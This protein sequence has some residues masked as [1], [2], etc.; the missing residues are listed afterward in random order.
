MSEENLNT[1]TA[2][3]GEDA[4]SVESN[5]PP[6]DIEERARLQGWV[7]KDEFKGDPEKWRPADEFVERGEQIV[8]ILKERT[9]TLESKLLEATTRLERQEAE[10]RER[11]AKIERMSELALQRQRDQIIGAYENAKLKAVEIGDTERYRQLDQDQR[12]AVSQHDRQAYEAAQQQ[13]QQRQISPEN[14][15]Q[16]AEFSQRNPWY[17]ID[18]EMRVAAEA[19]SQNLARQSPGITLQENLKETEAYMRKRYADKFTPL[20]TSA[21]VEAGGRMPAASGRSKGVSELPADARKQGEK[22]VAQGLFKNLAEY[23]NDYWNQ[24]A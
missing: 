15:R 5:S 7:P 1:G 10:A 18:Y 14:Q 6:A 22:F 17:E 11:F 3:P 21:S 4:P 23:A 19:Y 24:G 2:I 8:P 12:Q 20:R 9:R 16:L 13:E